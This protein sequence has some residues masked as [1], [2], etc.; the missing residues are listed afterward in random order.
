MKTVEALIKYT[1]IFLF[2]MTGASRTEAQIRLAAIGGVHSANVIE[3]NSLPGWDTAVKKYYS[4][5]TGF[6]I[7]VLLEIPLGSKG[8]FFQ[9]GLDYGSK[10]R[11]YSRYNDSAA[12]YNSDTVYSQTTL[13]LGYIE[14]PFYLTYKVPLSASH[15]SHF[16]VSLGPYFAFFYNGTMSVQN[17]IF[18]TNQY[19]SQNNDLLVGN[20]P[21]KYKTFDYGINAKAG[22]ELGNVMINAYF[23]RGLGN[24][25]TADYSGSFHHQ[26]VGGS[27]GIWLNKAVAPQP[28]PIPVIAS[29][30]KDSLPVPDTDHD[31]IDDEHDS[32]KTVPGLAR[33]NGCPVPDTD[34]DGVDD[35]HDSCRT[36]P[37]LARYNGCPIPDRDGDG[38]N[39]EEDK[40]PDQ[41][42]T[43]ENAGCPV[44]KK[45]APEK[46]QYNGKSV[47][48]KSS[49]SQLTIN[50]FDALDVLVHLLET[51]P[52]LHL[53]I[54]GHADSSGTSAMN[55]KLSKQRAEKV[56]A[57]L[58]KKGIDPARVST[59]GYGNQHPLADN[60]SKEGKAMNRRVE[61]RLEDSNQQK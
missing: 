40:C 2:L 25:Y 33:Y 59:V 7:G 55:I 41:P 5:R 49:S 22:F 17:R 18:S 20:A 32:C 10:G 37:G 3:N 48:F 42:G 4:P 35:E 27:L 60:R 44:Q 47:L 14:M 57:Y 23:S 43:R 45:E 15:S 26:L 52:S 38:V 54:E 36:V 31:G 30:T 28:K 6:Q 50:S 51:H 9:P 53:T 29:I 11:Q 8:F 24:F 56:K 1:L 12:I 16:F 13:K 39:D 34:G 19:N 58:V 46:I 61:F 21:D